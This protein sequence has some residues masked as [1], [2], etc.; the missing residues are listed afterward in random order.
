MN[1]AAL[2]SAM[3]AA[4]REETVTVEGFSEFRLREMTAG[5]RDQFDR[6]LFDPETQQPDSMHYQAKLVRACLVD[7]DTDQLMFAP[8]ELDLVLAFH[9]DVMDALFVVAERLNGLDKAALERAEKN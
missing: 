5:A 3:Q 8:N 4:I 2:I 7:S 9:P 6:S 1:K